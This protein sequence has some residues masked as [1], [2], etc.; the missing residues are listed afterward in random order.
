LGSARNLYES[1]RDGVHARDPEVRAEYERLGP[2]F[3]AV[4]E[5]L[6]ARQRAK[7]T[8]Q[9]LADAMGTTRSVVSR[10]ES[11]KHSPSIDTLAAAAEALGC[12]LELRFLKAGGSR[13]S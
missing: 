5:L 12:R 3:A 2:R 9:E 11:G 7:M 1:Y 13:G 8:Q 6:S 4:R 10:L